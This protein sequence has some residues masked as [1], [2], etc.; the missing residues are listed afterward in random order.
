M[1]VILEHPAQQRLPLPV[2]DHRRG[3]VTLAD[4]LQDRTDERAD[5]ADDP[6]VQ[7]GF[8]N[9]NAASSVTPDRGGP[10]VK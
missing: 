8:C 2:I 9:S 4:L 10:E 5:P 3:L 7:G 1:I 6:G